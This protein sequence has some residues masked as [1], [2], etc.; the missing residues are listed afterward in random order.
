MIL[1]TSDIH[2]NNKNRDEYRWDLFPWLQSVC[3]EK[4]VR[5]LIIGGDLFNEKDYHPAALVNRFVDNLVET[6]KYVEGIYMIKGNHDMIEESNPYLR[7][8]NNIPHIHFFIK[9]ELVR[10]ENKNWLFLPWS[11]DPETDWA[12]L[13][14]ELK[15]ADHIVAHQTFTGAI[16]EGG[17]KLSGV[18]QFVFKK[19]KAKIWVGDIHSPQQL[20]TL[21]Y[22]G[23]PYHV[24]FGDNYLPR[25]ILLDTSND[26]ETNLYFKTIRRYT[27]NITKPEELEELPIRKGDQIKVRLELTDIT[28]WTDYKNQI[29]KYCQDHELVLHQIE[30]VR[31]DVSIALE[32]QK[33]KLKSM[34]PIEIFNNF[35]VTSEISTNVSKYG[36]DI[37]EEIK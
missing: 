3:K 2:L 26:T 12:V 5:Y 7:W 31:K 34:T 9:P 4:R 25:C 13:D 16:V 21:T 24:T 35:C 20:D 8:I 28:N 19:T 11:P 14:Y 33:L 22:I 10:L 6:L 18:S 37:M 15:Q 1:L 36:Q 23:T 17:Y 29:I 27:I 30:S 32:T